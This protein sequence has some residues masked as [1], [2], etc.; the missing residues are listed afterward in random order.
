MKD[1]LQNCNTSRVLN[2]RVSTRCYSRP[3]IEAGVL[4]AGAY[5]ALV[6]TIGVDSL[7]SSI[8]FRTHGTCDAYTHIYS[9]R[10]RPRSVRYYISMHV[11][12]V[13]VRVSMQLW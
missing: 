13:R 10:I 6:F 4:Q 7:A 9:I 5:L 3:W 8:T 12:R 1:S 11:Q 2:S